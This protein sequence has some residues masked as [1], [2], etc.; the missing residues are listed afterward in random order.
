M[1]RF[2]IAPTYK[3]NNRCPMCGVFNQKK[4]SDW[5]YSVDE[6][7]VEIESKKI[8][9]GDIVIIS[10][11]EPTIY[12]H[13]FDLLSVLNEI[14]A[15]IT[16]FSNGRAFKSL[17]FVEELRKYNYENLLIPLFGSKSYIH[18]KITGSEGSYDDTI[19]GLK[20][21]ER[22]ELSYSVKSVVM[23]DNYTDLEKWAEMVTENFA[24]AR[25]ISIH[26]L[27]LQGEAN[28]I[29]SDLYVRHDVI[30][31]YVEKALDIL[32]KEGH[33]YKIGISA[34]PLCTIDPVYWKYN[35]LSDIQ[36]YTLIANDSNDIKETN[37]RNYMIKPE[38]CQQCRVNGQCE[39]P[40][41]MYEKLYTLNYL[42]TV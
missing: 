14:G 36:D 11:G 31:S 24:N 20:N 38:V 22:Y 16:I 37:H 21:L 13:F 40:W 7:K 32:D 26:G 34:F 39:W 6:L 15:R 3:C 5:K 29:A 8:E 17:K 28:K 25:M 18:D 35:M 4:D 42:K 30:S 27:H 23:K 12:Q 1:K 2:Y 33:K 19:K 41:R 9:S 10:G